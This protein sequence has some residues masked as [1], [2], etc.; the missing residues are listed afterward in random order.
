MTLHFISHIYTVMVLT[1]YTDVQS[2]KMTSLKCLAARFLEISYSMSYHNYSLCYISSYHRTTLWTHHV[3]LISCCRRKEIIVTVLGY[4]ISIQSD[5]TS[6]PFDAFHS[7]QY[8]SRILWEASAG[9]GEDMRFSQSLS[10]LRIVHCCPLSSTGLKEVIY[11]FN[12][13]NKTI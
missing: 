11:T 2:D 7:Q 3:A 13:W 1:F 12:C 8:H 5:L 6:Y 9:K 10:S 4:S